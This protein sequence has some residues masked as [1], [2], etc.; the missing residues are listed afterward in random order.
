MRCGHVFTSEGTYEMHERLPPVLCLDPTTA[1]IQSG[2]N[3]GQRLF[4][5]IERRGR[6]VWRRWTSP[7]EKARW[8]ATLPPRH[9]TETPGPL[10]A[11][12]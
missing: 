5:A 6:R 4:D 2:K 8:L 10:P 11:E 3:E 7:E 12:S 9:V 1:T